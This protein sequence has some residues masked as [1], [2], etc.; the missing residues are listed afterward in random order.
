MEVRI[1]SAD[2]VTQIAGMGPTYT[3]RE[4]AVLLGR[5]FSWLDQRLR[6][7]DFVLPDGTV[8]APLRSPGGYRYLTF[9]M[10]KDVAASCYRHRWF[11]FG[12]LKAV[13]HQLAVAAYRD[14]GDHEIP[15]RDLLALLGSGLADLMVDEALSTTPI[16]GRKR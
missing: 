2:N 14:A 7:G 15:V 13:F 16:V 9:E 8:L 1:M 6:R 10:L 3:A 5:S 11:T 4:A 12:E